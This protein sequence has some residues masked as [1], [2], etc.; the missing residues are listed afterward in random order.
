MTFT[1]YKTVEKEILDCLQSTELAWRYE[2]GDDVSTKYRGGDE[3]EMLLIPILREKLKELNP[4][5]ITDDER[6]NII[7]Q[8]LRALPRRQR[9]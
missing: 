7:I 2:L 8:K 5:V 3:Q 1:E 4:G 6:A 9:T